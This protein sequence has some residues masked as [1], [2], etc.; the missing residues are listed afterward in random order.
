MNISFHD[1]MQFEVWCLLG[2]RKKSRYN[3]SSSSS[4]SGKLSPSQPYS[5]EQQKS[6][7]RRHSSGSLS[8]ANAS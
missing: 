7:P 5:G 4:S 3:H 2:K 1:Q 8:H 6:N